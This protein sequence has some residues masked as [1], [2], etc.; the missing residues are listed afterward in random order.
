MP[1]TLP[2]EDA[3]QP[4]SPRQ[5]GRAYWQVVTT[6]ITFGYMCASGVIFGALFAFVAASEQIFTDVFGQHETFALWFAGVAASLAAANFLNSRI[7][8]KFGMRRISHTVS[9]PIHRL[10][11]GE[12]PDAVHDWRKIVAVLPALLFDFWVFRHA[13][14]ELYRACYGTAG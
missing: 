13:R 8:E 14:R 12:R 4:L 9:D 7:V 10:E 1:E 5:T 2:A 3:R 11:L 6:R